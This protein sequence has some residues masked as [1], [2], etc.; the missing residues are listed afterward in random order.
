MIKSYR[1]LRLVYYL[2][3]EFNTARCFYLNLY[4][5]KTTFQP[6]LSVILFF[7][8]ISFD[9]NQHAITSC[10]VAWRRWAS[11]VRKKGVRGERTDAIQGWRVVIIKQ[12]WHRVVRRKMRMWGGL[13]DSFAHRSGCKKKSLVLASQQAWG[14]K[15]T[16]DDF[17]AWSYPRHRQSQA[18]LHDFTGA[19]KM[20]LTGHTPNPRVSTKKNKK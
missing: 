11:I 4:N 8:S 1:S 6:K 12:L 19:K 20:V 13:M 16:R 18:H 14:Q 3:L 5:F 9:L 2:Q 15:K 7:A 10:I 17:K